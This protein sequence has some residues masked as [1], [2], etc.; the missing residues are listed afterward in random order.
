[1]DLGQDWGPDWV[2]DADAHVTEPADVW[3]ERLPSKYHDDA[4]RLVRDEKS[5]WDV[6]QLGDG[7]TIASVGHTATAGW[8]KKF[9]SAPRN[10]DEVPAAA[11]DA[12][13]RLRYMDEVGIW[14]QV[15]YPN[16]VASGTRRS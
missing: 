1:M 16:V 8:P 10:M 7:V 5:G 15:M 4:P 12:G 6:W 14:A 3:T 9:P 2:I 11:H 13:A